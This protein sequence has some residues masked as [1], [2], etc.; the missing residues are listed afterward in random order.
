[1]KKSIYSILAAGAVVLAMTACSK[2][3]GIQEGQEETPGTITESL[4]V[5]KESEVTKVSLNGT[6]LKFGW[7][8]HDNASFTILSGST[9]S[10]VDSDYYGKSLPGKMALQYLSGGVRQGYAVTPASFKGS[11]D[12]TTL[13]V[14]YP[15]RYDISADVAAGCYDNADGAHFIPFPM[16]A[17]STPGSD[18]VTFRSIG[19]LV[20]VAVTKIPKGTKYIYVTFNQTVTGDFTV[21]DPA[22]ATPKVSVSD[23]STPSTVRVK[24]SDDGLTAEKDIVLYIPVPTTTGLS[25][26]SSAATKASVARNQGYEFT[27][28]AISRVDSS[29]DFHII[30]GYG[31]SAN[32]Q[33]APGNLYAY[34]EG[35][36]V[37]YGQ[38]DVSEQFITTMGANNNDPHYTG[39]DPILTLRNDGEYKDLFSWNEMY[40]I[41][42]GVYPPEDAH[43]DFTGN[44]SIEIDGVK[45]RLLSKNGYWVKLFDST[46]R[47]NIYK[48]VVRGVIGATMGC[49]D[50]DLTGSGYENYCTHRDPDSNAPL[51]RGRFLFPD[52]YVDM[53]NLIGHPQTTSPYVARKDLI[54]Y[55]AYEQMIDN[56]AVFFVTTGYYTSLDPVGLKSAEVASY[57]LTGSPLSDGVQC[58][59]FKSQ[60]DNTPRTYQIRRDSYVGVRLARVLAM[61]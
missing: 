55:D 7:T 26:A 43:H 25:I 32:V 14:N 48:N 27:A 57:Y 39:G 6:T 56:G 28:D 16:V 45:W 10:F 22:S 18:N 3:Q 33:F 38:R 12:G 20:K 31:Q 17:V 60:W 41:F 5:A 50:V 1:M 47:P 52:G 2:E 13:V 11:Y 4:S 61:P 19:A 37:K 36:V 53:T 34:M 35:G 58:F 8:E 46:N 21:T 29:T 15:E 54:S 9:Y 40:Y 42:R 24:I 59:A 44:D 23:T 49:V 30:N 51:V